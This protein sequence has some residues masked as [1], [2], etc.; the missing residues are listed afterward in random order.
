MDYTTIEL[1]DKH[2]KYREENGKSPLL[3][4][5]SLVGACTK[6]CFWMNKVNV[7]SHRGQFGRSHAQRARI[8]GY[9]GL[10]IAE[11]IALNPNGVDKVFEM[12]IKSP[13]H[14]ENILGSFTHF[15]AAKNGDYWCVLFGS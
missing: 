15:G 7:L 4:D 2:N 3:I 8:E 9:T 11:N 5:D 1:L 6:H 10:Y 14:L 13:G 12:W